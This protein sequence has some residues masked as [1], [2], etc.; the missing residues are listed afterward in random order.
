MGQ[1]PHMWGQSLYILGSLLAEVETDSID[2]AF[3]LCPLCQ[4]E[5]KND[6]LH[7]GHCTDGSKILTF[8][9]FYLQGF[10]A[11]GEIDPLNRRFSTHFKPDVVVQGGWGLK[12][13]INWLKS[14]LCLFIDNVYNNLLIFGFCSNHPRGKLFTLLCF[15][16]YVWISV[17]AGRILGD[18][19]VVKWSWDHGPDHGAGSAHQGHACSHSEPCLCQT[20]WVSTQAW[21]SQSVCMCVCCNNGTIMCHWS[22]KLQEIGF[23]RKALQT[24]RSSG[25]VQILRDQKPLLYFCSA[26]TNSFRCVK[27]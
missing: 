7:N 13:L 14:T 18:S 27:S 25:N 20:G 19:G 1:L 12:C 26:G 22:R 9:Y 21:S 16:E 5:K 2:T 3:D 11:P 8:I 10:L 4:M 23:E 6:L 24:H 17:C 15:F